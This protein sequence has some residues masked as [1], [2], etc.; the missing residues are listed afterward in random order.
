MKEVNIFDAKTHLSAIISEVVENHEQYIIKKRGQKVAKI[1]PYEESEE[2]D[3]K[4]IFTAMDSL[5][6]EIGKTGITQSEIRKMRD[7]GRR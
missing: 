3:L 6:K 5:R 7:E 2:V 1:V 4:S